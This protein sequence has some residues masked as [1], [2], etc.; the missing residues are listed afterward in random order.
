MT[1]GRYTSNESDAAYN[2][3][4]VQ[5]NLGRGPRRCESKSLL[6]TMARPKFAPKSTP[7]S[8]PILKPHHLPHRWTRPTYDTKRHPGSIC[9]FST[10]RW[11][12]RRTDRPTDGPTNRQIVHRKV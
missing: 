2:N 9:R 7:S 10:M 1:I 8:G 6:V 4:S 5:S 12:G 11:T 3:K